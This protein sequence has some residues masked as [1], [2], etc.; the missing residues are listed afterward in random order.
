MYDYTAMIPDEFDFQANDI[1]AVTATPGDGQWSGELLDESRRVP[2][3]HIFP[4]NY[5]QPH[6]YQPGSGEYR[7]VNPGPVNRSS[8]K[9]M[10]LT[11]PHTQPVAE[12]PTG[13][14]TEDGWGVLFYGAFFLP[15][16]EFKM[17]TFFY[18]RHVAR[19]CINASAR[20]VRL[21]RNDTG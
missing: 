14:Y 21:Y 2:G 17:L 15:A 20:D 12:P 6:R 5:V 7:S 19:M 4:S 11:Q 13:K 10:A 18:S 1:I 8:P 16:G 9:S 3:R